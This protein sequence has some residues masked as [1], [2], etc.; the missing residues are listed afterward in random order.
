MCGPVDEYV[1]SQLT[2]TRT[3]TTT[4]HYYDDDVMETLFDQWL[5][6]YMAAMLDEYD[7]PTLLQ[8]VTRQS[9]K[10]CRVFEC[11]KFAQLRGVCKAHGGYSNC[12][13]E[14]CS[15]RCISKGVCFKHG[16]GKTC[17][18]PHCQRAIQKNG[19]CHRHR[20]LSLS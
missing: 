3:T 14:N 11:T 1:I 9:R 12:R 16:G 7:S 13:V 4:M 8:S 18:V 17:S 5:D 6:H 19:R 15:N 2:T 20:I 10:Q